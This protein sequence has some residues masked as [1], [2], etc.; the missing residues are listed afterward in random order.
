LCAKGDEFENATVT[1]PAFALSVLF[2]YFSSPL[3]FAAIARRDEA[4]VDAVVDV[5]AGVDVD[6]EAGVVV[7]VAGA[8][9]ADVVGVLLLLDPPQAARPSTR[10]MLLS[11]RPVSLSIGTVSLRLVLASD[12]PPRGRVDQ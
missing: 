5:D 2:V 7:E 6:V 4:P 11:A 12:G 10:T 3:G 1:L 8:L 9:G